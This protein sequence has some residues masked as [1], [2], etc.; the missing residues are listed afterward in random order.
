VLTAVVVAVL[1]SIGSGFGGVASA[2]A[3]LVGSN[4]IDGASLVTAPATVQLRFDENIR[5]PSVVIVTGPD[6]K[7]VDRGAV[8]VVDNRASVDVSVRFAGQYTV[9]YRVISSDGHPVAGTIGFGFHA[10][11]APTPAAGSP[12]AGRR[13]SGTPPSVWV[14]GGGAVVVVAAVVLL[15]GRRSRSSRSTS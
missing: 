7:R 4:P 1:A 12:R 8:H 6:G 10:K 3:N 14:A 11:G 13:H 2:H 15:L 5:D 9:A